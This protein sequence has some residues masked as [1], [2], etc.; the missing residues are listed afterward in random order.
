MPV[1]FEI[2]HYKVLQDA[3]HFLHIMT[4]FVSFLRKCHTTGIPPT[5]DV[6]GYPHHSLP[7]D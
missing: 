3:C 6:T 5:G 1:I 7:S 4:G 2:L